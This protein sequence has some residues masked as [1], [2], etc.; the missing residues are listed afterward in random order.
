MPYTVVIYT[1]KIQ[2]NTGKYCFNTP[3]ETPP[4]VKVKI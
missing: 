1:V 2:I 4:C 3:L